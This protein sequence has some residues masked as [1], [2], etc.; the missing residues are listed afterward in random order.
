MWAGSCLPV[1]KTRQADK[2]AQCS[3]GTDKRGP[4]SSSWG[5]ESFGLD[6]LFHPLS[7]ERQGETDHSLEFQELW[8]FF[9]LLQPSSE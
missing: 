7:P 2:A 3:R 9:L 6:G 1:D 5:Q 4:I 8:P